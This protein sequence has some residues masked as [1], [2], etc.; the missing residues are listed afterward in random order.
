M[1]R[2]RLD[3]WAGEFS[4]SLGQNPVRLK[5]EALTRCV[6][7]VPLAWSA[8]DKAGRSRLARQFESTFPPRKPA[9][10]SRSLAGRSETYSASKRKDLRCR[11]PTSRAFGDKGLF[12]EV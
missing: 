9:S 3:C 4:H 6:I 11:G 8:Q 12:P 10:R 2:G 5:S 1:G 7:E